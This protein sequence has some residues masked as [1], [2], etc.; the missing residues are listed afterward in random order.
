M[1]RVSGVAKRMGNRPVIRNLSF[2]A[3]DG[4][5]NGLIGPNGAGK[6]TTLRLITGVL[7]PD[8]GDIRMDDVDPGADFG[9]ARSAMGALL[10]H[11]GLY[12][13][14]TARE[15]LSYFG[16]LRGLRSAAL[17]ARVDDVVEQLGIG[18][19]ADRRTAGFSQGELL[20]VALGC[21]ILHQPKHI[22]LDEP[23]NGLDPNAIIELR[24]VLMAL[25][26]AGAC[27]IFS[28]HVLS[29]VQALCD[30]VV[31]LANGT[32]ATQGTVA[33]VCSASGA[34]ALEPA[35]LQLTRQPNAPAN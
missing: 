28:S 25:R 27:V 1:I 20:K 31:V 19:I 7:V 22:L 16:R 30:R 18:H 3:A 29:E 6:T 13:R 5:I 15:S 23:T 32:V 14:L 35:F 10:D 11:T 21:S 24:Q 9:R 33:E 4:T 34:T 2:E 26:D 17:Q 12:A 8:S